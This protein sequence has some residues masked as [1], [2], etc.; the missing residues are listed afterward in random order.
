[1]D[2]LDEFRED[3]VSQL[4][5]RTHIVEMR[6]PASRQLS[7]DPRRETSALDW[8]EKH[9]RTQENAS[10]TLPGPRGFHCQEANPRYKNTFQE[11]R[12]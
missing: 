12:P 4:Q 8:H 2:Y 11:T 5:N 9:C 3:V 7:S 10:C 1:M 6:R